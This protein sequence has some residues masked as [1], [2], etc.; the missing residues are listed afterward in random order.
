MPRRRRRWRFGR[1]IFQLNTSI[2]RTNVKHFVPQHWAAL[3]LAKH[4]AAQR[5]FEENYTF[6]VYDDLL[7]SLREEILAHRG[8]ADRNGLVQSGDFWVRGD[9]IEQDLVIVRDIY[10]EDA[11]RTCLLSDNAGP[12]VVIDVGA[13]IGCFA[14]KWHRKNPRARIICVEACPENLEALRRNVGEFAE[15]VHAACTYESEPI[16]L[17]NALRPNC[18][19]TGGSVVVPKAEL[20]TSDLR[21]SGYR[22]WNDLREPAAGHTGGAHE[23]PRRRSH[24]HPQAGLRRQR[25][26]DP[27]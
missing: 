20:E 23:P 14:K 11:Y 15:V 25:V 26:F 21:Q 27:G 17:L 6:T 3:G 5:F 4:K 13:H 9:N 2:W 18:E 1:G 19:S 7:R 16:A 10:E 24:R 22:Y 8:M 12:Q